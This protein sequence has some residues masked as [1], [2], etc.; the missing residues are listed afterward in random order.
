MPLLQGERG[1]PGM[2]GKQ[3]VKVVCIECAFSHAVCYLVLLYDHYYWSLAI[4][5]KHFPC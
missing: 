3:G 2:P 5:F 4:V 1:M